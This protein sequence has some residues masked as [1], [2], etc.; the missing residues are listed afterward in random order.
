MGC[1]EKTTYYTSF[2]ICLRFLKFACQNDERLFTG[3]K[4]SVKFKEFFH[5]LTF[6]FAT[7]YA[8]K[9]VFIL[10]PNFQILKSKF[11]LVNMIDN[12]TSS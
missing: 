7:S 4:I 1:N 10:P 6:T 8:A 9:L 2:I 11:L 3:N 12:F 5:R